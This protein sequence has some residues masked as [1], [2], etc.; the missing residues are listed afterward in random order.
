DGGILR[1]RPRAYADRVPGGA[2]AGSV[3]E[4]ADSSLAYD[5][6]T[7]LALYAR[8]GIAQY[9]IV[10]LSSRCVELYEQ[11]CLDG[12]YQNVAVRRAGEM[13]ALR[14]ADGGY[15]EILADRILP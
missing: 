8:A 9:V 13:V 4:V 11:P 6:K 2:D 10:N 7:K 5:R 3:I 1:G 14:L 15:L 12:S